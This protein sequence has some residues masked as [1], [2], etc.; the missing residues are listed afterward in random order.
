MNVDTRVSV[1]YHKRHLLALEIFFEGFVFLTKIAAHRKRVMSNAVGLS[2]HHTI[3]LCLQPD[4]DV[5]NQW[6]ARKR[7]YM[8]T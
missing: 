6:H 7:C 8:Q 2:I 4:L 1:W 3:G 5:V